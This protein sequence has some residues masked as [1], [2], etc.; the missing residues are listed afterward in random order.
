LINRYSNRIY[1]VSM[2]IIIQES[3]ETGARA[4][5]LYNNP[6]INPYRNFFNELYI[7][8]SY[9]LIQEVVEDLSFPIVIMEEGNVKTTER[10][11]CHLDLDS[12]ILFQFYSYVF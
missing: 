6:L 8:K 2:S 11:S 5:I 12:I 1:P 7:L 9:P 3:E 4:E 10:Y